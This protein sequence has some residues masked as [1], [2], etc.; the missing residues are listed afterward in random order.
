MA[1]TARRYM[2]AYDESK[3]VNQF[4]TKESVLEQNTSIRRQVA[5]RHVNGTT[6]KRY[7]AS[8][9]LIFPFSSSLQP[10][11]DLKLAIVY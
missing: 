4:S 9:L 3:K 5:Q 7:L 2:C 10:L 8:I 1:C 11:I 6:I